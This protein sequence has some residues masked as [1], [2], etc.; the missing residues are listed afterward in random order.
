MGLSFD[1]WTQDR[2]IILQYDNLDGEFG[3]YRSILPKFE[4]KRKSAYM[5]AVGTGQ[6]IEKRPPAA[7]AMSCSFMPKRM[8]KIS[9]TWCSTERLD[10]MYNDFVIVR[11][12]GRSGGNRQHDI[13]AALQ[14]SP[15]NEWFSPRAVTFDLQKN[16]N[17]RQADVDPAPDSEM[18]S[19]NGIRHGNN[20][21]H[22]HWNERLR[23]IRSRDSDELR[24]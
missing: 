24:E 20:T 3:L 22:R 16:W 19:R 7:T 13:R 21:E 8:S 18:V 6:A 12:A 5:I 4:Q 9:S 1:A 17:W 11:A 14:K 10:V 15:K 2:S 23:L